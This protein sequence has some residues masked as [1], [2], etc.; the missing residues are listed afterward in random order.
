[1]DLNIIILHE[2]YL[3]SKSNWQVNNKINTKRKKSDTQNP[4]YVWAKCKY[5]GKHFGCCFLQFVFGFPLVSIDCLFFLGLFK[6]IAFEKRIIFFVVVPFDL[7]LRFCFFYNS[8]C[9]FE[10]HQFQLKYSNLVRNVK[11]QD[12]ICIQMAEVEPNLKFLS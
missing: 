2:F 6:W 5:L 4:W 10:A 9:P 7:I 12:S 1:M 3:Q 8:V 11:M